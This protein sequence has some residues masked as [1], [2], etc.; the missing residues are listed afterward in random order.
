[1]FHPTFLHIAVQG[2]RSVRSILA[3]SMSHRAMLLVAT[4]ASIACDGFSSRA[5]AQQLVIPATSSMPMGFAL[6]APDFDDSDAVGHHGVFSVLLA[7]LLVDTHNRN[8][9][10]S[11]SVSAWPIFPDL[12]MLITPKGDIDLNEPAGRNA[13]A[14]CIRSIENILTATTFERAA[15]D[16]AVQKAVR[17]DTWWRIRDFG[18]L[19][20][21]RYS[22][23]RLQIVGR[24]ALAELYRSDA[25]VSALVDLH[26]KI[27]AAKDDYEGFSAWLDRQRQSHRMGFYSLNKVTADAERGLTNL[28]STPS[29]RPVP[30]FDKPPK[31][32]VRI[33][34]PANV[35]GRPF[36]LVSCDAKRSRVCAEIFSDVVC[37]KGIEKAAPPPDSETGRF[38]S[39]PQGWGIKLLGIGSWIVIETDADIDQGKLRDCLAMRR[40]QKLSDD[41]S[42]AE[43]VTWVDTK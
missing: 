7:N 15:F 43:F 26:S 21:R 4:I 9:A 28:Q 24:A 41:G 20:D 19:N 31:D 38:W 18:E 2:V 1:M 37:D 35:S 8:S 12:K 42:S 25:A 16:S 32:E 39:L 3:W 5:L 6:R 27:E 40:A 33:N 17:R 10:E 34:V 11:C 30:R 29:I 14:G 22:L 23:Y 13:L 36:I